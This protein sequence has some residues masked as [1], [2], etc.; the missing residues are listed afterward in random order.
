MPCTL[1][2]LSCLRVTSKGREAD[3]TGI[4]TQ[5]IPQT[6]LKPHSLPTSIDDDGDNHDS[7][8][9]LVMAQLPPDTVL[10]AT[11]N[12]RWKGTEEDI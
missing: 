2:L 9:R 12:K 10:R 8:N 1:L 7:S 4:T 11:H 3:H 6:V 5:G